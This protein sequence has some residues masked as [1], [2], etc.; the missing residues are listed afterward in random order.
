MPGISHILIVALFT[1]SLERRG[2]GGDD[3][4]GG[5]GSRLWV[6]RV[7]VDLATRN[8]SWPIDFCLFT[9]LLE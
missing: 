3:D 9:G 7:G 2:G 6:T 5:G 1:A 4:E 8:P